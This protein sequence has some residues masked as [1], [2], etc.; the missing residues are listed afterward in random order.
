MMTYNDIDITC[1]N[2]TETI[3]LDSVYCLNALPFCYVTETSSAYE[4]L[5]EGA[6][7]LG[8]TFSDY[9]IPEQYIT[10][11]VPYMFDNGS[12]H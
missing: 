5:Y 11:S 3:C 7:G 10:N 1:G 9:T 4:G 2:M 12:T 6:L 8:K